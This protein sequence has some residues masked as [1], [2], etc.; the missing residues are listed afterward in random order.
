MGAIETLSGIIAQR[1]KASI[2]FF[3]GQSGFE[4]LAETG[5]VRERGIVQSIICD[6]C[7][8]PHDAEVVYADGAYG[9][10]CS[11]AGFVPLDTRDIR[12]VEPVI[13]RL[14]TQL[15]I[16]FKTKRRKSTPVYGNTWRVG[17]IDTP[18]GDLVLFFHPSMQDET[19]V[20]EVKAA[21]ANEVGSA[22]RLVITANGALTASRAKA[23]R[24][25]DIVEF[26]E[27]TARILPLA[28]PRSVAGAPQ[29]ANSGPRS[30]YAQKLSPLILQRSDSGEA[31]RGR[32][33][34]AKALSELY[35]SK[36]PDEKA[37]SLVTIKRFVTVFRAGS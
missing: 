31:L 3:Q 6:T 18:A 24:L 9:F 19:D 1:G 26:V 4:Q 25:C 21:L 28:D 34:E 10:F 33:E 7:D 20:A 23:V 32:N 27:T 17:S 29:A 13:D 22:F 15:A 11:E 5:L 37:P 30:P 8:D 35:R 12:S 16:A 14:V 36:F 2:G